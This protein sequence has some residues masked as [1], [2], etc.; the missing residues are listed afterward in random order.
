M[1]TKLKLAIDRSGLKQAHIAGKLGVHYSLLS[2]Y[3]TGARPVPEKLEQRIADLLGINV[4]GLR[5][6]AK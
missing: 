1:I 3:T 6:V 5:G 4:R 2:K